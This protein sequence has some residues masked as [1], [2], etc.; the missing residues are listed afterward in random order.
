VA[1]DAP[2]EVAVEHPATGTTAAT[3]RVASGGIAT[4]GLGRRIWPGPDGRPAHHLLDPATG[5]PAWTGLQTVTARGASTL[6]AETLAK[7]AW[8]AG[9]AAAR[10]LLAQ[11][12]GVLI[13]DDGAVER[14]RGGAEHDG[15]AYETA[16]R[17]AADRPPRVRAARTGALWSLQQVSA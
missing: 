3:L 17:G 5:A 16:S 6:E 9:P 7:T 2:W 11:R 1:G 15:G 8:L 4:S 14:V 10:R 13:H 12:G